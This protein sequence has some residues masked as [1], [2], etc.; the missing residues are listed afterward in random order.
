MGRAHAQPGLGTA[1]PSDSR[2][3]WPRPCM[4]EGEVGGGGVA[5]FFG[6]QLTLPSQANPR[7]S[8]NESRDDGG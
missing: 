3:P 7:M 8:G 2:V 6:P 5:R 4:C 1:F